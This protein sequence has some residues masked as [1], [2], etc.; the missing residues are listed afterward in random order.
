MIVCRRRQERRGGVWDFD[1]V[2]INNEN[3]GHSDK[4]I[5]VSEL[6]VNSKIITVVD[7]TSAYRRYGMEVKL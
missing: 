3:R 6:F 1:R 5:N 2:P 4:Q 7:S